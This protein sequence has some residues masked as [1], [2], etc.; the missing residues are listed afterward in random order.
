MGDLTD[1]PVLVVDDDKKMGKVLSRILGRA[2]FTDVSVETDPH[3]AVER[4]KHRDFDAILLDLHMPGVDGF[5]VMSMLAEQRGSEDYSPILVLTGDQRVDVKERALASGARDFVEKP[6]EPTEVVARLRNLVET[7]R[8]HR[9]LRS[10][11]TA[12]AVSVAERTAEVVA[13]KLEVLER[14]A[15]AGEYRD[16]MTGMHAKRVGRLSGLLAR[17]L[18]IDHERAVMIEQAAPLHD[19]GKIGVSDAILL[20]QGALTEEE[21]IAIRR[22]TSMGAAILSGSDLDLMQTAERIALTH[23]EHWN[24]LGYPQG[25]KECEIPLEGRIV[26]V[27]DAFDSMTNDRPYR[28]AYSAERAVVEILRWR[29]TQFAPDMVDALCRLHMSGVLA[30]PRAEVRAAD[31]MAAAG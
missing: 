23:H 12:L 21:V 4:C 24:G 25:L 27:A 22:H 13:A 17:E 26:A 5:G 16:D 6:F 8:L 28:R 15:R 29:G 2:G 19:I 10:F 20:K 11:N 9:R 31:E 30:R 7:R 3:A 1:A 18:R 14:L